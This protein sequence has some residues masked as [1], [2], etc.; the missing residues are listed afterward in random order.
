MSSKK[1][2]EYEV[3]VAL[4]NYPTGEKQR[5]INTEILRYSVE[6]CLK[7][8]FITFAKD[9]KT[10]M[11]I[12]PYINTLYN[13]V[14]DLSLSSDKTLL[15]TYISVPNQEKGFTSSLDILTKPNIDV[16]LYVK[17]NS[18]SNLIATVEKIRENHGHKEL[19]TICVNDNV[20]NL[21]KDNYISYDDET[22]ELPQFEKVVLGGTFDYLHNGHK[23]LLTMSAMVCT[24]ELII[25]VTS[26]VMLRNKQFASKIQ[27][28]EVR[29]QAVR[30]FLKT[31]RPSLRVSIV[32]IDDAFG[33]SI[34][35]PDLQAITG[36]AE[37]LSGCLAVNK[38]RV[39]KGLKKLKIV[40]TSRSQSFTLSSTFVRK[41]LTNKSSNI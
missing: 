22:A 23:R 21:L 7:K 27:S 2:A 41:Y 34:Q 20:E 12:H 17:N 6:K 8:L 29:K 24:S 19:H 25:G 13:E 33:P 15:D 14:W 35:L 31:I 26:D 10:G 28:L 32:V 37:T 30:E 18:T 9:N 4:I 5:Q 16:V 38:I 3:C 40:I 36:S 11:L 1:N 39:E